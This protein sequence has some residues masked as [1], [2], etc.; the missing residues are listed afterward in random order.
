MT[1]LDKII[2]T[3][4]LT[5][6]GGLLIYVVGQLVSQLFIDPITSLRK[7]VGEV[8]DTVI[9]YANI[10]ANPGVVPKET[11]DEAAE[12]LRQK[13][14]LLRVRAHAIPWYWLPRLIRLVPSHKEIHE[15][16]RSLI[17]LS[18][19]VH[20]GDPSHNIKLQQKIRGELS[21]PEV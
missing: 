13:A 21:L 19:G 17:G 6:L 1:E 11:A 3:S 2:L 15:A 18:N 12:A 4:C 20:N 8:A 5:I 7:A 9:F 16:S 14:A 10:Y